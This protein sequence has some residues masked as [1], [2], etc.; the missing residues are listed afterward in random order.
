M[1]KA[2]HFNL[3]VL[4]LLIAKSDSLPDFGACREID[5]SK[6]YYCPVIRYCSWDF[7]SGR[8]RLFLEDIG[9]VRGEWNCKGWSAVDLTNFES[10]ATAAQNNLE[11]MGYD[12]DRHDCCNGHYSGYAWSD[13]DESKGYKGVKDALIALGHDENSW[14]NGLP[15]RYD[16]SY[17]DELPLDVQ[18]LAYDELCYTRELWDRRPLSKWPEDAQLPGE[19]S[20]GEHEDLKCQL[21]CMDD[22]ENGKTGFD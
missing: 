12:E 18:Q 13:F 5:T 22:C 11:A 15:R 20:P 4:C 16:D 2:C 1:M 14:T 9:Y 10:L 7:Y 21:K 17:W 19:L 8:T 3:I 6:R